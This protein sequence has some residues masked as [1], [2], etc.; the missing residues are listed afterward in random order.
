MKNE[1]K[2]QTNI[3]SFNPNSLETG[4]DKDEEFRNSRIDPE[5]VIKIEKILQKN[6]KQVEIPKLHKKLDF[7]LPVKFKSPNH[8]KLQA[9]ITKLMTN[10]KSDMETKN[11]DK[12]IEGLKLAKY[13]MT[14]IEY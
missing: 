7:T 13:Y 9:V 2:Q 12:A 14:K 11:E 8:F 1:K 6:S 3:N 4:V 5:D 10:A